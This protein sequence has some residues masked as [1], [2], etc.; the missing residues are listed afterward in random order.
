MSLNRVLRFR[1]RDEEQKMYHYFGFEDIR[2]DGCLLYYGS[3][4]IGDYTYI[5]VTKLPVEQFTGL[6]DANGREIYENDII[7]AGAEQAPVFWHDFVGAWAWAK[8]ENWGMIRSHDVV[9]VGN[10]HEDPDLLEA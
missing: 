9:V 8:G 2:S 4:S 5:D 3:D 10:V 7:K 6:H 1:V